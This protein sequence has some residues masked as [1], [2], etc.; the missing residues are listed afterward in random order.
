M[1]Y[2]RTIT[3]DP[4]S[5]QPVTVD[6]ARSGLLGFSDTIETIAAVA[7]SGLNVDSV[8]HTDTTT[9]AV[10][11]SGTAGE[12]YGLRIRITTNAG[13]TDDRTILVQCQER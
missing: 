3:K 6:W 9:T 13:Y 10:I 7:D 11:S 1:N 2:L 4:D 12:E 8:A 5:V